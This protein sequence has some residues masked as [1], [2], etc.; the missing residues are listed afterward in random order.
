MAVTAAV[1]AVTSTAYSIYSGEQQQK[2]QKKSLQMQAEANKKA[3]TTALKQ[4][5]QSQQSINKANQKQADTSAILA[6]AQEA[7][8][9]NQTLLTGPMGIDPNQL[10]L[11][12][13]TLLGA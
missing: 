1:A 13:N 2:Q 10:A 3:E 7:S 5:S 6:A 11:G 12:R 4:E 8:G 9:Q